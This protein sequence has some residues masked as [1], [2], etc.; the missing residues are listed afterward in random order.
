MKRTA[1][2]LAGA[3]LIC[4]GCQTVPSAANLELQG[5]RQAYHTAQDDPYVQK[6]G[7]VELERA[8]TTLQHAEAEWR[9]N[10]NSE[11]ATHL[12]YVARQRALTATEVGVRGHAEDRI[13]FVSQ[14]R[15]QLLA[16][17]QT[18]DLDLARMQA[19]D[20]QAQALSA[21]QRAARLQAQLAELQAQQTERGLIVTMADVMF[22]VDSARLRPGA[23]RM[24][25]RIAAVL[26]DDPQRR[27]LIEGYSDSQGQDAYNLEL[28]AR[29][30][31]AV[32]QALVDR[33]ISADRID[34]QGLGEAY[35][36]ATNATTAGRQLNRRVEILFS[37]ATGHIASRPLHGSYGSQPSAPMR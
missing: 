24:L 12:A 33:G 18:R 6:Y 29:R 9:D 25:D 23:S 32:R 11:L 21:E 16:Q 30:A 37:D 27:V 20:A 31:G 13:R 1:T 34:A 4:A 19:N 2:L 14:Q 7:P 28:S 10:G 22:D 3:A 35:P 15:D 8:R 26:H 5:A 36:V 17:A